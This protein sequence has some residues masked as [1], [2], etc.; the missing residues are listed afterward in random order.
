MPGF[1]IAVIKGCNNLFERCFLKR[2]SQLTPTDFT[3]VTLAPGRWLEN[4]TDLYISIRH[5]VFND[6]VPIRIIFHNGHRQVGTGAKLFARLQI[7]Y[8]PNTDTIAPATLDPCWHR[9]RNQIQG[10]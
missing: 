2:K 10:H 3:G 4:I 8:A 1:Q 5:L 6:V 7:R 9:L